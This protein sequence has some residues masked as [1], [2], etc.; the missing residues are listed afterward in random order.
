[1]EVERATQGDELDQMADLVSIILIFSDF[2]RLQNVL[3]ASRSPNKGLERNQ[4]FI[5]ANLPMDIL[6]LCI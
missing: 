1:M 6:S 4:S 2:D 5:G 3:S